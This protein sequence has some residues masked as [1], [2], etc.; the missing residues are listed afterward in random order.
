MLFTES[1]SAG[2]SFVRFVETAEQGVV[3]EDVQDAIVD[4]LESDVVTVESLRE[5]LLL[6]VKA[7]GTSVADAADFEMTWIFRWSDSL[8]VRAGGRFPSGSGSFIIESLVRS[9]LVVGISE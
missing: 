2:D 9:N 8:G 3:E 5:E 1:G 7:E 4:L 6:G